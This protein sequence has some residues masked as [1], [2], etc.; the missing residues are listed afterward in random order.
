MMLFCVT[1]IIEFTWTF[2]DSFDII[3]QCT[4]FQINDTQI[5]HYLKLLLITLHKFAESIN[6]KNQVY[7]VK[8][9]TTLKL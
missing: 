6:V 1:W 2:G 7:A 5:I 3:M 8:I 4:A 9:H